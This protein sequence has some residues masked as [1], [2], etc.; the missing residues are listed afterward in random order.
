[1]GQK[2]RQETLLFMPFV[3]FFSQEKPTSMLA[4]CGS[5]Q[6]EYLFE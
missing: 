3:L 1:M 2:E 6:Y 4:L 5:S